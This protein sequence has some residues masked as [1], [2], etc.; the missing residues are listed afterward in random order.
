[1]V[2]TVTWDELVTEG[3]LELVVHK[4]NVESTDH[5]EFQD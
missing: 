1:V 2:K 3:M 5:L 4:E